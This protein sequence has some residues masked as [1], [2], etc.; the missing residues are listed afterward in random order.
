MCSAV[1]RWGPEGV[2]AVMNRDE[3]RERAPEQLPSIRGTLLRQLGPRD[4]AR[5][6]TWF[7]ANES[8]LIAFLLNGYARGELDLSG[9]PG[10]PSRGAIL[11]RVLEHD[12]EAASRML[13]ERLDPSPYPS[14]AAVIASRAGA[15]A[16][17]WT[18]GGA[19]RSQALEP[20]WHLV[21]SSSWRTEDV[22][23]WREERFAEWL[24]AGS[25][26][27]GELPAFNLLEVEGLRGW[28]PLMTRAESATRS[29]TRAALAAGSPALRLRYWA[30]GE[31]GFR[32]ERPD[33]QLELP[34]R[35][36]AT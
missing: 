9:R 22:V 15:R 31:S 36:T 35:R 5:G 23:R 26:L 30:R 18:A 32:P 24:A 17:R 19:W 16:F 29:I 33:A 4:G 7:G 6:G 13:E 1:L 12:F 20:G 2:L 8:G 11:D 25:P 14:F 21:T 10:L 27:H 3:L 28:S 34:M